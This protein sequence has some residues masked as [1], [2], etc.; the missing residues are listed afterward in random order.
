MNEDDM[1]QFEKNLDESII[2]AEKAFELRQTVL[3]SIDAELKI[4]NQYLKV[5]VKEVQEMNKGII[6]TD[7]NKNA[8]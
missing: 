3:D 7:D 4:L 5:I 2:R 8:E 6:I 1:R